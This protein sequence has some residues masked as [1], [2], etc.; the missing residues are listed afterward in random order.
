MGHTFYFPPSNANITASAARVRLW[1]TAAASV[2]QGVFVNV[3]P[4]QVRMWGQAGGTVS[5]SITSFTNQLRVQGTQGATIT[6]GTGSISILAATTQVRLWAQVPAVLTTKSELIP[7]SSQVRGWSLKPPTITGSSS[8]SANVAA[9]SSQVRL[10]TTA[11]TVL[12]G[13]VVFATTSQIRLR[14]APAAQTGSANVAGVSG[15]VHIRSY[16]ITQVDGTEVRAATPGQVRIR[17]GP[18]SLST[19]STIHV[20]TSVQF[21]SRSYGASVSTFSIGSVFLNPP[22]A[23]ARA[24]GFTSSTNT[25]V[26]VTLVD[27]RISTV[28]LNDIRQTQVALLDAV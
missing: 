13:S 12:T 15:R 23:Q 24:W 25:G 6:T 8:T 2:Q 28:S 10:R 21:R 4:A 11:V 16:G 27:A 17:T 18:T 19:T 3:P 9:A 5:T 1:S 22:S 20:G 26:S 7:T 14:V